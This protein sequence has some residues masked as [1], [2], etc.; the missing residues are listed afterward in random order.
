MTK[1]TR[2]TSEYKHGISDE[3]C[4]T[5]IVAKTDPKMEQKTPISCNAVKD[6]PKR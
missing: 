4:A 2:G 3:I 1:H 6:S 5:R